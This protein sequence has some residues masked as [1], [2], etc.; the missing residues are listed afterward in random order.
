MKVLFVHDHI[1]YKQS[2]VYYSPG[3]LKADVWARYLNTGLIDSFAVVSRGVKLTAMREGLV[4][5]SVPKVYFD[6]VYEVKGGLDYYL[7]ASLIKERLRKHIEQVDV[8]IIRAPSAFGTYAYNICRKLNKPYITEI[9]GCT[10]DSNWNYGSILG[11]LRAPLSFIKNKSVIKNSIASLYVTEHFLQGRYP[12]K[13]RIT[14]HASNVH[15]P[16]P[17]PS[18][19]EAHINRLSSAGNDHVFKLGLLANI[20]VKYKGYDVAI[21]ALSKLKQRRPDIKFQFLAAGGG[22]PDYINGIIDKY[23]MANE[24]KLLGQLASGDEVFSCLDDLDIYLQPSLTEGL[25]RSAIEAMSRGCPVLAS[26]AGGIPELLPSEFL[27]KPGD[28]EKL[29]FDI[30]KL[31][32]DKEL[33]IKAAKDNFEKSKEYTDSVLSQRRLEFYKKAFELVSG[34][35]CE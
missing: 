5:S 16:D 11:K 31:I 25:P 30:E 27:H 1:I 6:P 14:T 9:V 10:W 13:A 15:I 19:L 7:K 29:S 33:R 22:S 12:S 4:K 3:G 23:A 28:A 32:T 26:T 20:A 24:V 21:E 8:V 18:V 35:S 17:D 34:S 2:D